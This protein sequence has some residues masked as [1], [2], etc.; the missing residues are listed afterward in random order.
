VRA[1]NGDITTFDAPSASTYQGTFAES[2]NAAGLIV[3]FGGANVPL[4]FVR[5]SKT[6]GIVAAGT[7]VGFYIDARFVHH[8]FLLTP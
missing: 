1:A 5:G 4:G 2:I 7:I 3:G 6:G 8:G